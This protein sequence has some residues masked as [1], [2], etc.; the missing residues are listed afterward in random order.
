MA[1]FRQQYRDL[2]GVEPQYDP[3]SLD[4]MPGTARR[5]AIATQ[6]NAP[7]ASPRP[8]I[9]LSLPTVPAEP[10]GTFTGLLKSGAGLLAEGLV[11]IPEYVA[12]HHEA[13]P[14]VA[15]N[16]SEVRDRL[17]T[18]REGVYARMDPEVIAKKGRELLTLDPDRTIWQGSPWQVGQAVTYKLVEQ[19]PMVLATLLPGGLLLR[20]GSAGKAISYLGASEAGLSLGFIQ[21]DI[22]DGITEL[23]D[24]E[25][26]QESPR[27]ASLLTTLDKKQAREQFTREAQ[28]M[29]PVVGGLLVGAI[30]AAA[31]RY[32]APVFT[33]TA[34]LS[35]GQ[36]VRRG[37]L[38][39]GLLQEGPQETIEQVAGNV[40]AAAYDGD[41]EALEGAAESYAQGALLG[42]ILGGTVTGLLGRRSEKQIQEQNENEVSATDFGEFSGSPSGQQQELPL[43]GG[44]ENTSSQS[45]S[46]GQGEQ[47]SLLDDT[48]IPNDVVAAIDAA[49]LRESGTMRD[50]FV[51][52]KGFQP[53]YQTEMF[54][55][56]AASTT[57]PV[58]KPDTPISAKNPN[59]P[60]QTELFSGP[61]RRQFGNPPIN[62]Y[63]MP[64]DPVPEPEVDIIAQL[65]QLR[66]RARDAVYLAPGQTVNAVLLDGLSVEEDFARPG[67]RMVFATE[68][69]RNSAVA[70]REKLREPVPAKTFSGTLRLPDKTPR[71]PSQKEMQKLIGALTGAGSGK[72]VQGRWV[73]QRLDANDAVIQE[74]LVRNLA[75]A[76]SLIRKWGPAS[77]IVSAEQALDRRLAAGLRQAELFEG[78]GTLDPVR[79][80]PVTINEAVQQ[81]ESP[82]KMQSYRTVFTDDA[83]QVLESEDFSS[84]AAAERYA[85]Q[86]SNDYDLTQTDADARISVLP[87]RQKKRK[88]KTRTTVKNPAADSKLLK[89]EFVRTAGEQ[90]IASEKAEDGIAERQAEEA[91][92]EAGD[93]V[94]DNTSLPLA[95]LRNLSRATSKKDTARIYLREAEQQL[96]K[97]QSQTIDGFAPSEAYAFTSDLNEGRYRRRFGK[98]VELEIQRLHKDDVPLY[99]RGTTMSVNKRQREK[100][101]EELRQ[102]LALD[103]PRRRVI[104]LVE[105]ANREDKQVV[106]EQ[107]PFINSLQKL[108]DDVAATAAYVF[109]DMPKWTE[110]QVRDLDGLALDVAH[111]QA[112]QYLEGKD[113]R[114]DPDK[115]RL[116]TTPSVQRKLILRALVRQRNRDAT[117]SRVKGQAFATASKSSIKTEPL[118]SATY[119]VDETRSQM[120]QRQ[121][122]L[123]TLK[124]EFADLAKSAMRRARRVSIGSD[125]DP[126]A[127]LLIKG[128]IADTVAIGKSII[129]AKQ[130]DFKSLRLLESVNRVLSKITDSERPL[131]EARLLSVARYQ[132]TLMQDFVRLRSG[133]E[134]TS[135]TPKTAEEIADLVNKTNAKVLSEI[136]RRRRYSELWPNNPGYVSVVRPL[137]LRF[138]AGYLTRSGYYRPTE[139]EI[140]D[141]QRVVKEWQ[142]NPDLP[143]NEYYTPLRRVLT[144]LGFVWSDDGI[145]LPE[146]QA[147]EAE[148]KRKKEVPLQTLLLAIDPLATH[149]QA[150]QEFDQ[151]KNALAAQKQV[152]QKELAAL[153]EPYE[154]MS[155]SEKA[156]D[157]RFSI[158]RMLLEHAE[159][160]EE[161]L[162]QA[163]QLDDGS[164]Q[165]RLVAHWSYIQKNLQQNNYSYVQRLV[166]EWET[167]WHNETRQASKTVRATAILA[168]FR[169]IVDN[170]KTTISRLIEAEEKMVESLRQ[171]NLIVRDTDTLAVIGIPGQKNVTYRRSANDLRKRAITKA[172]AV[173]RMQTISKRYTQQ[174]KQY[175]VKAP[176][177]AADLSKTEIGKINFYSVW[178]GKKEK[179]GAEQRSAIS[180]ASTQTFNDIMLLLTRPDAETTHYDVLEV[181]SRHAPK[182]SFGGIL[183]KQLQKVAMPPVTM[184]LYGPLDSRLTDTPVY[185]DGDPNIVGQYRSDT[186]SISIAGD[187]VARTANPEITLLQTIMHEVVHAQ[188]VSSLQSNA[189]LRLY[190]EDLRQQTVDAVGSE[191]QDPYGDTWYGL[192]NVAEFVAE[193][194]SNPKFQN[195]LKTT[196][197]DNTTLWDRFTDFIKRILG[198]ARQPEFDS[199]F[200]AL[201][202]AETSLTEFAGQSTPVSEDTGGVTYDLQLTPMVDRLRSRLQQTS[203]L[204]KQRRN[205]TSRIGR[206]RLSHAVMSMRQ[207]LERY[208][209]Y[210]TDGS[211]R[212]YMDSFFS[213][214]A[215]NN[216][217]MQ[218]PEKLSRQWTELQDADPDGAIEFSRIS[219]EATLYRLDPSVDS[220]ADRNALAATQSERFATLRRRWNDLPVEYK[221]LWRDVTQYYRSSLEAETKLLLLNAL[222]GVVTKGSGVVMDLDEFAQKYTETTIGAFDTADAIK[223]EFGEY[224]GETDEQV[225][226]MAQLIVK[227]ATVP[228]SHLGV[229]FPLMRYGDYVFYA[230]KDWQPEYYD[231][232]QDANAAAAKYRAEDP[233]LSV[234]VKKETGQGSTT[235]KS[236]TY[237]VQVRESVFITG[238]S[239]YEVEQRRD[240]LTG[241]SMVGDVDIK[242]PAFEDRAVI[243]S[244]AA[245]ASI[246][247]TLAGNPA[248]Q[249]AIKQFYLRN[250]GDA[251][252]RKRELKRQNRRGADYDLAHR[253]FA[254]YALQSAYYRSQLA[255]GWQMAH[256]LTTMNQ[257][258][259][260]RQAHREPP[261]LGR[262]ST[263]QLRNVYNTLRNRDELLTDPVKLGKA[264]RGGIAL[265]Q[266]YMLT[267]ASYHAINS[268]QPWMVTLPTLAGRHGWRTAFSAMKE[269][270]RL[271]RYDI[272]DQ[273]KQSKGGLSLLPGVRGSRT[274]AE[275]AF[276]VFSQLTERLRQ[277]GGHDDLLAMLTRLRTT[278]VLEVSP[279]TELRTVADDTGQPGTARS[280]ATKTLDASRALAHLVEVNNRV[281]SAIG[282][283]R[284]EKTQA[285]AEGLS[286][287]EA[288]ERAVSYAEKIVSQT[289][290]DYSTAN[291][292]PLFLKWPLLFQFMQW[293]QHIYAHLVRAVSGAVAGRSA[294]TRA[295]AR[296]VLLGIL[297][298]HALVGG[299]L[300]V[301]LQPIKLATGLVALAFADDDDPLS[302]RDA[303]TGEAFDR[304]LT[305]WADAALGGWAGTALARGVPAA[306]GA[307]L[308]TRMSLGTLYFIDLRGDTPESVLGS[309]ASSFGGAFVN[310]MLQFGRGVSAIAAEPTDVARAAES[311]SPKFLRDILRTRRFMQEG[312]VNRAGDTVVPASQFDTIDLLYQLIG[313]TPTTVSGFY[314]TQATVKGTEAA[315]RQRKSALIRA[316]RKTIDNPKDL[317]AILAEI[318]RFNRAWPEERITRSTL[319]QSRTAQRRREWQYRRYGAAIDPRRARLYTQPGNSETRKPGGSE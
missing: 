277:E 296:N 93:N 185:I 181:V 42:G 14:Q 194:F 37:A 249:Q 206:G 290:F 43:S 201:M 273:V 97:E 219:T 154:K 115:H 221:E 183:A 15:Q 111:E 106:R 164:A 184:Q 130:S 173:R 109:G 230:K 52:S 259:R 162:Q 74:S 228:E 254:N 151:G 101:T 247:S 308:S 139:E 158:V 140:A 212:K 124:K 168:R 243:E 222:R 301:A 244:N 200:D 216:E 226:Q 225:N 89:K 284:L 122:K 134:G 110:A 165:N 76:E 192:T 231:N 129:K 217:L 205:T 163:Q 145:L 64:D 136:Q 88:Q 133:T 245:L 62:A 33:D 198:I 234:S 224:L 5:R 172:Q 46:V 313:F 82:Q 78:S 141:L 318:A 166:S 170:K 306:L 49:N 146:W 34:G 47:L 68:S 280:I 81:A 54:P 180:S 13:G 300:G 255:F 41:R 311:F 248:A 58:P 218:L 39:E 211:L 107:S 6:Q 220:T 55:T 193:A 159:N 71:V 282:A 189:D 239:A 148:I 215:K 310:Q 246:L 295:E 292:P 57:L 307:D 267:S 261:N 175:K 87:I 179:G 176:V 48:S 69:A 70:A 99:V 275:R 113:S 38:S 209:R 79:D 2:F 56:G 299:A 116:E 132:Y 16:L 188:T 317:T 94:P 251:S 59:D 67:D 9:P 31:G 289:Q 288:N 169:K 7:S 26:A 281:L 126:V 232:S 276:G 149:G 287:D 123:K 119:S 269:A 156:R 147:S 157:R 303:L 65:R 298:T 142:N 60:E 40:A 24:E 268:T 242:S 302:T 191:G 10:Q 63:V 197:V 199:V 160:I 203:I 1:S 279:L 213:R 114:F 100:L 135:N 210:F 21:N 256:N 263:E 178:Q 95:R 45:D 214:N 161:A 92:K 266:F 19:V 177:S 32:L 237:R 291:K 36:R 294:A 274:A 77:R 137:L 278:Q 112:I 304:A 22:A 153:A 25:L 102:I 316:F 35:F 85:D 17:R 171:E 297:G 155:G 241:Y 75:E 105:K 314:T 240:E 61:E 196:P 272:L 53:P 28:G 260:T 257:Y 190:V 152:L 236:P 90:A 12:R 3:L 51:S 91:A 223:D 253:N 96:E 120:L 66:R 83:G 204:E 118:T 207:L 104:D 238:E 229:Y 305:R 258:L 73:I 125:D 233:T 103:Q 27:F 270:Q 98:L 30:S 18:W 50:M 293:S 44:I 86:L 128:Y 252:F 312:L 286:V 8:I 150:A 131:S 144:D 187:A 235:S 127:A 283:Y 29:A 186:N 108:K 227:L 208:E 182:N 138:N 80:T 72:P 285:L 315:V 4:D 23:T 271:I 11:G 262:M 195:L 319:L 143:N 121:N 264:V 174:K 202:A 309:L 265:T 84:F 167:R 250:L 20:A 117:A